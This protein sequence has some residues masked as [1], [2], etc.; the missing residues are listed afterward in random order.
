MTFKDDYGNT[1]RITV[2]QVYPYRGAERKETSF[3]LIISADYEDDDIYFV[4]RFDDIKALL[5]KL[6]SF[7]CGT[8]KGVDN[9]WLY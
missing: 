6:S 3:K 2:D 5:R 9:N 4:S 8:F 1:A 7:S